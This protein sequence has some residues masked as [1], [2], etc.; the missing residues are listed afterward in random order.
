M[1]TLPAD[2]AGVDQLTHL[3]PHQRSEVNRS[4]G[5]AANLGVADAANL[6]VDDALHP[7]VADALAQVSA[8]RL[9]PL[10]QELL[11]VPSVT[12]S[13]AESEAQHRL[14]ARLRQTGMDTDL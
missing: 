8:D 13:A 5:D 14:A 9:V 10:L 7:T 3:L 2:S 1:L 6:G 4:G 11:A 12:G